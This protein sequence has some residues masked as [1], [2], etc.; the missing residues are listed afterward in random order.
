MVLVSLKF[1]PIYYNLQSFCRRRVCACVCVPWINLRR[2]RTFA[3]WVFKFLEFSIV[4]LLWQWIK[5]EYGQTISFHLHRKTQLHYHSAT[6]KSAY[7]LLVFIYIF[8]F[9]QKKKTKNRKKNTHFDSVSAY[10]NGQTKNTVNTNIRLKKRFFF[11]T[12]EINLII[13]TCVCIAVWVLFFLLLFLP[14]YAPNN[15][16]CTAMPCHLLTCI[17]EH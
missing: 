9:Y 10:L 3:Y 7:C 11:S 2:I 4:P 16:S 17:Y 14:F 6:N 15:I 5:E 1:S 8:Q 13:Y 12:N